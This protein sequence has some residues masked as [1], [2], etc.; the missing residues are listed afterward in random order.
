MK[1]ANA[2][3]ALVIL[4]NKEKQMIS[5]NSKSRCVNNKLTQRNC[6]SRPIVTNAS[7]LSESETNVLITYENDKQQMNSL[8][9]H[10]VSREKVIKHLIIQYKTEHIHP[11]LQ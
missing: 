6:I 11:L 8:R 5:N 1:H 4:V 2:N 3:M 7:S 10:N 9:E